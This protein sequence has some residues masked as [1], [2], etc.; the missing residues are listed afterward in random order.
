MKRKKGMTEIVYTKH[1]KFGGKM[2]KGKKEGER[3]SNQTA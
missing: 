1:P 2:K 3:K